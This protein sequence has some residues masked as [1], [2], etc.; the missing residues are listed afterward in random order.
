MVEHWLGSWRT[1]P[2]PSSSCWPWLCPKELITGSWWVE[3][4]GCSRRV[5]GQGWGGRLWGGVQHQ[6]GPSKCLPGWLDRYEE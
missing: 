3:G 2:G 5:R 4:T 1:E 6:W